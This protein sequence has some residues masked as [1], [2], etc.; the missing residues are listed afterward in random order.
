MAHPYRIHV[1]ITQRKAHLAL[2]IFRADV[3]FSP[4]IAVSYTHLSDGYGHDRI[5]AYVRGQG[6]GRDYVHEH[7]HGHD[8]RDR[9]DEHA[10]DHDACD[11]G[12]GYVHDAHGDPLLWLGA[13]ARP[14][15]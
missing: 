13:H 11:Q 10:H 6:Y 7:A 1:R 8:A 2:G 3:Q 9:G 14:C 12:D 4:R 5:H 15:P